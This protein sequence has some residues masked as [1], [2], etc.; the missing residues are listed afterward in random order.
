MTNN[1][2]SPA[3]ENLLNN[4]SSWANDDSQPSKS[5]TALLNQLKTFDGYRFN[6]EL[7][8]Q[9]KT[10]QQSKQENE[11]YHGWVSFVLL[12]AFKTA[13]TIIHRLA[14]SPGRKLNRRLKYAWTQLKHNDNGTVS[15]NFIHN[16]GNVPNEYID[17]VTNAA[18]KFQKNLTT[19]A[20]YFTSEG[21]STTP[22]SST[23]YHF[24]ASE[25][26]RNDPIISDIY[27]PVQ[28]DMSPCGI[29]DGLKLRTDCVIC[30]AM[31]PEADRPVKISKAFM[32]KINVTENLLKFLAIQQDKRA[33]A[34][35]GN[36]QR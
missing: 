5:G 11:F 9:V 23:K 1:K 16:V 2:Y 25:T 36:T 27:N 19:T 33:A 10:H 18:P 26:Q 31:L 4:I 8:D 29:H 28:K 17:T 35:A 6:K 24:E 3:Y 14:D 22:S 30:K 32:R 15:H 13:E 21:I 34:S 20:P 7:A 12:S